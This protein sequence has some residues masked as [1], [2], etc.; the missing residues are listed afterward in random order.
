MNTT[1]T[2]AAKT[3]AIN[4]IAADWNALF[5]EA[6]NFAESKIKL[7][8]LGRRVGIGI[9]ELCGH[10]QIGFSFF[11]QVQAQLPKTLTFEAA[12]K[13]VK[14]ANV[15][16]QPAKTLLDAHNAEQLLLEA[17]GIIEEPKRI[18][19]QSSREVAPT[20]FFFNTLSTARER[21]L[22]RINEW[23]SWDDDTRDGVRR[24]I[25]RAEQWIADVKGRL[26]L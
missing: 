4:S 14:L 9:Q 12:K 17:T 13:C 19:S 25:E 26:A 7:V 24:E 2:L 23:D 6:E 10:A 16:P 20:T 5:I 11:A 1:L 21:I 8:N 3:A 22:S 15:M 18:E